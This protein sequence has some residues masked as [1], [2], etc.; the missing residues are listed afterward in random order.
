MSPE[1]INLVIAIAPSV[2]GIVGMIYTFVM[3]I[4]KVTSIVNDFK[5]SNELKKNNE[6]ISALLQDNAQLKK[7]N[8][9]LLVELT[10]V[11]PQGW[12]DDK[13]EN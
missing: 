9:K 12:T 3:A 11:R 5:Q 10:R 13:F 8:E 4:R 7:M 1:I 2:A 6:Q